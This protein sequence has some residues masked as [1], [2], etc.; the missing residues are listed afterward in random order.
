MGRRIRSRFEGTGNG[1]RLQNKTPKTVGEAVVFA[2]ADVGEDGLGKGGL[3]GYLRRMARTEPKIFAPLLVRVLAN[4]ITVEDNDRPERVFRTAEE[5]RGELRKRGIIIDE[6]YQS[7]FARPS[8]DEH[9][10]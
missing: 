3:V 4:P 1:M 2:A 7:P 5:I 6:I 10:T 9:E 8:E